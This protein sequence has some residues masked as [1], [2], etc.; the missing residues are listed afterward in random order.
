MARTWKFE[1]AIEKTK[2]KG[3]CKLWPDLD[4]RNKSALLVYLGRAI[5]SDQFRNAHLA[6]IDAGICLVNLEHVYR[7]W[8]LKL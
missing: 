8:A 6:I 2:V 5:V 3:I 4:G 1:G 7:S